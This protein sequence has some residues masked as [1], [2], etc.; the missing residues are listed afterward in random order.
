MIRFTFTIAFALAA[1]LVPA[2][3]P[4]LV[5]LVCLTALIAVER[6]ITARYP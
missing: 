2:G 1:A 4:V 3:R 5:P 6:C